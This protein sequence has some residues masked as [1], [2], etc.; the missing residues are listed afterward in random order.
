M[1]ALNRRQVLGATGLGLAALPLGAAAA[2]PSRRRPATTAASR[3]RPRPDDRSTPGADRLRAQRVGRRCAGS[4]SGSS[5]TR[6]A[7]CSDLRTSST[8]WSTSGRVDMVG[9]L[10]ARARLPR[11]RPGRRLRG[12]PPRPAHRGH[13]LRR[14]RRHGREA[15]R[16]STGRPASRPSSSTSRTSA[17]GST[18]TSG[19]CTPRCRRPSRPAPGSSCSTG[20]TR[21]AARPAGP[22]CSTGFTS[23]VG[24]GA[25]RPA[26]RHDRRRAGPVLRRRVPRRP[27]QGAGWRTSPSS[28][29]PGW[30]REQ[31]F[32][33]TGLPWVMPSPNM[34]TPDTA[35]LYPG[36]C[37][38]E[39]H[40]PVR[41]PGHD[42]AVRAHRRAVHRLPVGRGAAGQGHPGRASSARRTSRRRSA[43]RP[44]RSAA[45][46]R[47][48][49]P[50]P[51]RVEAIT[52]RDAHDGRGPAALPR[53]RL[54]G[55]R[56]AAGS[57]C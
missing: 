53:V 9:G 47:C 31:T 57:T 29:S 52:R 46:S 10:R 40:Q 42:P 22:C 16:L 54:A 25:D 2:R 17:R 21:S 30:S 19:R 3:R 26:A 32:A 1:S 55:R 5:P 51:S 50:T 15:R 41:G 45:A 18:P 37:L 13:G 23:G 28:R 49:S 56:R 36:T 33:D 4:G 39:A 34:P 38:F 20:P 6:P 11:H 48:T 44:A 12:Q 8:R 24:P 27:T 7:S 14:L 35:L 43:S